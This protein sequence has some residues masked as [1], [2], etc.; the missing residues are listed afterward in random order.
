MRKILSHFCLLWQV[1]FKI[2]GLAGQLVQSLVEETSW[3]SK[4]LRLQPRHRVVTGAHSSR[5]RR[6]PWQLQGLAWPRRCARSRA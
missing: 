3:T 4:S 6:Q 1:Q 2:S 5:G